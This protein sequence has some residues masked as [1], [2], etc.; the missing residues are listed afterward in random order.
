MKT[1]RNLMFS[2]L[3]IVLITPFGYAQNKK[4]HKVVKDIY[5]QLLTESSS[6]S[7]QLT[8]IIKL[9]N[10]N[11]NDRYTISLY[12][13]VQNEWVEVVFDKI[14]LQ[15]VKKDNIEVT[16]KVT[17][18][19][20]TECEIVSTKFKHVWTVKD[21]QIIKFYDYQNHEK[22]YDDTKK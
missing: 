15:E 17:G 20:P 2:I 8:S 7:D 6:N 9:N 13:I 1:Y 5:T 19:Q 4:N 18:R 12:A 10:E 3:I 16:G 14:Q 21:G 22:P 11:D